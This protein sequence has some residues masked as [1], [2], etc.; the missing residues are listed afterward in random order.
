MPGKKL[1]LGTF[2]V[3]QWEAGGTFRTGTFFNL[4]LSQ[5]NNKSPQFQIPDALWGYKKFCA[6]S[7]EVWETLKKK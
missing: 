7:I 6:Y 2:A 5:Q 1:G 4:V 3:L